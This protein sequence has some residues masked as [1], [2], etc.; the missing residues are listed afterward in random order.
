MRITTIF[1]RL[2]GIVHVSV[3]GVTFG[4]EGLVLSVRPRWRRSRCGRCGRRAPRYDRQA[5]RRWQHLSYGAART[6]LAYA[7][8]RVRCPHC[9]AVVVEAVPWA[10]HRSRF[11]R[12]FEEMVAYLAQITHRTAVTEV[13]GIAWVTVGAILTRV[14][15]ERLDPKR[16]QGLRHIGVD[17]FSY[18]KRH[19]YLTVVVDHDR[20]R[21]VW[22]HE[23]RTSA[24]LKRFFDLLGPEGRASI[25]VVTMDMAG[26]YIKAVREALPEAEIV[27]DRFHVQQLAS[28]ALDQIRRTLQRTQRGTPEGKALFQTRF[29]LLKNSSRLTRR[30]RERL[31]F[32]Q[33]HNRKLYRAY[34]LKES[35]AQA[36]SFKAPWRVERALKRWLAWA[37]RS[38]LPPFV[39]VA[40][41]LRKHLPGILAYARTRLTNAFTEG[42]NNRTRVLARRA[43]GFHSAPPLIASIYLCEGGV[44]LEPP[45]P[46]P[47]KA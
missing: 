19:R 23:G 44:H 10:R 43:F 12:P 13:M 39:R 24:T 26:G 41:T 33:K 37:S 29:A 32:V 11:T 40:R 27:F 7:P 28:R 18:R 34:L 4:R 21:V 46:R 8:W 6:E 47:T 42:L 20:R 5:E 30:D 15:D 1:R 14:V 16:F 3:T 45:L 22:A 2:L 17:E 38:R 9:R 31:A 36:L 25:E 35:L